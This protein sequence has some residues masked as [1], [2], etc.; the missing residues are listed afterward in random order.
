MVISDLVIRLLRQPMT[1]RPAGVYKLYGPYK[2]YELYKLK[3]FKSYCMNFKVLILVLVLLGISFSVDAGER[4]RKKNSRE[5]KVEK[6]SSSRYEEFFQGKKCE[7]VRG[8]ITIH[9]MDGKLYFEFPLRLL[10]KDMLLGSTITSITDNRFG[11]VG[12]KPYDPMHVRF[13]KGDSLIQLR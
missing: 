10:E 4:S 3:L 6:K 1:K 12:E 7:T 2:P 13:T 5:D 11:C 8:L 9:K